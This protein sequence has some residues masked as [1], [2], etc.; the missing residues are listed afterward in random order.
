MLATILA[1][2]KVGSKGP[3]FHPG[4]YARQAHSPVL[5]LLDRLIACRR[6]ARSKDC[7]LQGVLAGGWVQRSGCSGSLRRRR[8][9]WSGHR[10][11]VVAAT[12]GGQHPVGRFGPG[13][14]ARRLGGDS[15]FGLR[16]QHRSRSANRIQ[17]LAWVLTVAASTTDREL[18]TYLRLGNGV[19]IPVSYY[20]VP[21]YVTDE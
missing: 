15:C 12:R 19:T 13:N 21:L 18:V 1:N 7:S 16:G 6:R 11:H 5:S 3:T 17:Q 8:R 4:L 10:L 2:L 9:R 20:R 14:A